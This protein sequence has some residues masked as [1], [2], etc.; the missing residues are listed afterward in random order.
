MQHGGQAFADLGVPNSGGTKLFS[1]SGH[2]EKPGNYEVNM[3]MPF[4]ELLQLAGGVWKGRQLKAVIPGGPSTAVM[5]A[6]MIPQRER[7][8]FRHA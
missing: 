7:R 3:G 1:V 5:K 8:G 6:E 2:V 4:T